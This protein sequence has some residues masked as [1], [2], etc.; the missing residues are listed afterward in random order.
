[1]EKLVTKDNA[2][3]VFSS[4]G[5]HDFMSHGGAKYISAADG[6]EAD[7]SRSF[8][9]NQIT[10]NGGK[11]WRADMVEAPKFLADIRYDY[12]EISAGQK[13]HID[14]QRAAKMVKNAEAEIVAAKILTS[15]YYN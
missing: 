3:S 9:S 6:V 12:Q 13:E 8:V 5:A 1:M 11:S 14:P 4:G 15:Q 2:K 10:A 7:A